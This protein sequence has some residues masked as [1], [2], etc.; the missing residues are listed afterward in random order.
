MIVEL[1]I[2]QN[3]APSNL[4]RDDTGSPKDCTF[5]GVRRARISSQA[6][7]RAARKAFLDYGLTQEEVGVRTRRVLEAVVDRLVQVH[8]RDRETATKVAE[9]ALA[10]FDL[11]GGEYLL[12]VSRQG[13]EALADRCN[14][15]FDE[16]SKDKPTKGTIK[17]L[18][19]DILL[20]AS[21]QV[22]VALFGRMVAD[23]PDANVDAASQ[24]AHAISTHEVRPEFDYFTA[25]DDLQEE[26]PERETG[27]GH[28]NTL[29]FNSACYYRYAAVDTDQLIQNLGGDV[30]LS[31][32]GLQAF[33]MAMI[34]ELPSGKQNSMAAH[35]PPSLVMTTVRTRGQWNLANAFEEPVRRR[36]GGL[37]PESSRRLLQY[38]QRLSEAFDGNRP[39]QTHLVA[40]DPDLPI[41]DGMLR[42][43]NVTQL[44]SATVDAA[45]GAS[46]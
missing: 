39:T 3:I 17:E 13:I 43:H 11:T 27:A 6:L 20:D 5:G 1:H 35:N 4:N 12:F 44:V 23:L 28:I 2:I 10:N 29:E 37:V 30:D 46:T 15:L 42:H 16:L 14:E 19:A 24:V 18:T 36:D 8:S 26:S 41:P 21:G 9:N 45:M 22:D 34:H 33:L 40:V 7:K 38:Y 31:R 25:V 32:R